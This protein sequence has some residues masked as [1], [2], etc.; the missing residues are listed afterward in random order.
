MAVS[1]DGTAVCF[2][3]RNTI[4]IWSDNGGF[5]KTTE[6]KNIGRRYFTA[7]AF[8][9]SGCFLAAANNDN[10]IQYFDTSNWKQTHSFIWDIGRMRSLAFSPNGC[11]AAAGSDNGNVV[12]WDVEA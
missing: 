6:L 11:L 10:T 7:I 8:H 2:A 9:P 5:K 3:N 12:I 1:R 4:Q